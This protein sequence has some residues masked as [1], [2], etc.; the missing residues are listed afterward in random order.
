M[1]FKV[2]IGIVK[3]MEGRPSFL[4]ANLG[5]Q[6]YNLVKLKKCMLELNPR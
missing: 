4:F 6:H 2:I 1:I 3:Y 5:L